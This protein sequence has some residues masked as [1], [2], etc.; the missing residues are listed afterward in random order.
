MKSLKIGDAVLCSAF[1]EMQYDEADN[2]FVH[3]QPCKLFGA[4]ITG[5]VRKQLGTYHAGRPAG[6]FGDDY[7]QAVLAHTK[8]VVLWEVRISWLN[9]PLLVRDEDLEPTL[10]FDLPL[11][12]GRVELIHE[13]ADAVAA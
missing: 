9:K 10:P 2:R 7:E 13:D 6:M 3:V 8:T 1:A 12:R 4:V 5:K 11:T